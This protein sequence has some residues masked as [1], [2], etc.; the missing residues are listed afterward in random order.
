M[1]SPSLPHL[2]L[3]PS[4]ALSPPRG[5]AWRRSSVSEPIRALGSTAASDTQRPYSGSLPSL[6][7]RSHSL[8]LVFHFILSSWTPGEVGPQGH[9]ADEDDG[10]GAAEICDDE[11]QH[12]GHVAGAAVRQAAAL[13]TAQGAGPGAHHQEEQIQAGQERNSIPN[14]LKYAT[15]PLSFSV[16]GFRT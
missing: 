7:S 5:A 16:G 3:G 8:C 6:I 12:R 11:L 13:R 9:R 14:T 10:S 2:H 4:P 1:S 15:T